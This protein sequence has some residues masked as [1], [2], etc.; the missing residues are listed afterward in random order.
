M[1]FNVFTGF[2]LKPKVLYKFM[3]V[4]KIAFFI[5]LTSFLSVSASVYSQKVSL[6]VEQAKLRDVLKS[7][8]QQ[9]GYNFLYSTDLLQKSK[10]V[11]IDVTNAELAEVL[12]QCFEDQPLDFTIKDKTVVIKEKRAINWKQISNIEIKGKVTDIKGDPLA[13]VSIKLKGANTYTLTNVEG[14]Y[15]I[16]VPDG[17]GVLVFSY[18]GFT[19]REIDINNKKVLNVSL[20]EAPTKL[21][22]IVVVGYGEVSRRDLTGAVGSVSV[23]DL[24]KAPVR[25]FEEALAGRVA[26]VQVSSQDGQPGSTVDIVIRGA[27]S[28]SQSNSPLYVID[29]FPLEDPDNNMI[30]PSDIA[31]I[32][33]LKDASA[34]AIYGARG[35]NGVVIITTKGGVD[36]KA[37]ISYD[38]YYGT[39]EITQRM[40]LMSPYEFIKALSQRSSSTANSMYFTGG[41]TLEDYKDAVGFDWQDK[42]FKTASMQNHNLSIRGGNKQT[43]YSLSGSIFDQE[44]V[45]INSG[46]K[47]YQTRLRLDQQVNDNFKLNANINYS[48]LMNYGNSPGGNYNAALLFQAMA[49]RPISGNPNVNLEELEFDE[50]IEDQINN[51][52]FNPVLS[53]QNELRERINNT[54]LANG[55]GEYSFRNFKLK[56]SGGFSKDVR[57]NNTFNNSKTRSGSPRFPGAATNGVNGAVLYSEISSYVNENTLT[58]N[59]KV[60]KHSFTALGGFTIQG[61]KASSFGANAIQVPN[62][63]LGVSGLDEGVPNAITSTSTSSNLASFLGRFNYNYKSKYLLTASFRADGSSKFYTGNKWGYFPSAAASWRFSQEEF[64]KPLSFISDAKLRVSAGIT[65]NNRVSDFA[66]MS[67]ID[68]SAT[69]AYPFNNQPSHAAALGELRN[70]DLLWES[71]FQSDL[72]L[73]LSFLKDKI[74]LSVDAYSKTTNDLLLYAELPTSLGYSKSFKNI[75][76]IG[77]KGLEVSIYSMNLKTKNFSW[78]TNFNIAL[79]RNEVKELAENQE[80]LLSSV[81]WHSQFNQLSPYMAKIGMPIGMFYGLIWEGNYQLEDFD[82]NLLKS[83]IPTNGDNRQDIRPGDIKYRDITGDGVVNFDDYT[84]IGNPNPKHFGG[85]SNNFTYKGFDLNFFF[86]WSYGNDILNAN[87]Y[88]FEGRSGVIQNHFASYA[89]RW[90]VDNPTNEHFRIGGSGPAAYSSKVVEDGSYLRLKTVQFGY[91]FNPKFIKNLKLSTARLYV[92]AQ[93]LYTWTSYTGFDAEVSARASA[94]TPGF[95][96]SAYPRARTITFGLN[97]TL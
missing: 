54:L 46:Y 17:K 35:A 97:I 20:L 31:S 86:Q 26:G 24:Q 78:S 83:T 32:E 42:I 18:I 81:T 70:L 74:T 56:I 65:G 14:D 75:G 6:N 22:E 41:K 9:T 12:N 61:R 43:K 66:Y 53:A 76:E 44:G 16:K 67:T 96:F 69:T 23:E 60:G 51:T 89:N 90:S 21:N 91:N 95:D 33:I 92:S 38:G 19:T 29:G 72:G 52:R 80:V 11:S 73:D 63:N 37:I 77:N 57:K 48:G 8:K 1:K 30:N 3:L 36:G 79:N 15:S 13:G 93:N 4:M 88:I 68:M 5:L 7:L 40:E 2:R 47:R 55:Y 34:T 10:S 64:M 71:T 82:G 62:D 27:N 58:W 39:Q 50:E 85:L 49:Y 87:R 59:K 28:I 25:S 84:I 45:L 94:L